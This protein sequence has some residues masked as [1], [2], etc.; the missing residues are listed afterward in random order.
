MA[1]G[2]PSGTIHPILPRLEKLGW[3]ESHREDHPDRRHGVLGN[4]GGNRGQKFT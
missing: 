2:L 3:F 4:A 1:S